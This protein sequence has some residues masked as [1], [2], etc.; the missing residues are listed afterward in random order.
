MSG[1]ADAPSGVIHDIGYQRYQGPRLSP[2][3]GT[4]A[5]F[6]HSLRGV[7]GLGRPARSKVI[8]FGLL[9][10]SCMPALVSGALTAVGH[11]PHIPYVDYPYYLQLVMILF[12]AAQAP[13]LIAGDARFHVLALY[14]SRPLERPQYVWAKLAALACGLAIVLAAPVVIMYGS[15]LLGDARSLTDAVRESGQAAAGLAVAMLHAVFL[16][17]VGLTLSAFTRRRAFGSL[18]VLATYL[19]LTTTV[20]I[21]IPLTGGGPVATTATFFSPFDLMNRLAA[22]IFHLQPALAVAPSAPGWAYGV[23]TLAVLG[24]CVAI[25][26]W[27]YRRI[28]A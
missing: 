3:Y 7:F 28:E 13:Q 17:A 24:S 15:A 4:L 12:V 27:R 1:F 22:S 18:V 10:I 16:A 25:L 14:F 19:V 21:V 8:P 6:T 11:V 5:L 2:A 26:H 23:A 9:A 20:S